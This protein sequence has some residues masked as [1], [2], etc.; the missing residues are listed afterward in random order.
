MVFIV[1]YSPNRLQVKVAS[2]TVSTSVGI[3]KVCQ[4]NHRIFKLMVKSQAGRLVQSA[5]TA[6]STPRWQRAPLTI[7]HGSIK[8]SFANSTADGWAGV[9]SP[10]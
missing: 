1:T 9:P 10:C 4:P 7:A 6:Q 8:K 2:D 5:V 3:S